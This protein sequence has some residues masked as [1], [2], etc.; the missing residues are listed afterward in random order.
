[1][2]KTTT[3]KFNY[4]FFILLAL[5]WSGS[6]INIKV[7]VD[8]LPPVFC[9]MMRIFISMTALFI[10]FNLTGKKMFA[11]PTRAWPIWLAGIFAQA[12]PFGLL[13]YG[14]KF[15]APAL[16]SIIN[17]TVSFWAL[18]LGTIFFRDFS[19]WTPLKL[20]G[21]LLGF[22]GIVLIFLPFIHQGQSSLIGV[23]SVTGMAI[24]YAI[25]GLIN[26]HMIFNK[27]EVPFETN[28]FQQHLISV[29]VLFIY[30]MI[31]EPWPSLSSILDI[32]V[33]SSFLYLGLMATAIAWVIYFYLLR[34]WGAVRASS[35]MYI[36]PL[37]AICWDLIFLQLEPTRNELI[38][39]L[40]ILMGV[41][42][43]QWVRKPTSSQPVLQPL[44]R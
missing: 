35:V 23:I 5:L 6:F 3:S 16:A 44:D 1:M 9:A 15:I 29:I 32:K 30:S 36:V 14:E 42:L 22:F 20:I 33:L 21:L 2:N 7:V 27:I 37:L 34:E 8:H 17:S 11:L 13:F 43:I 4:L 18:L 41:I 12:L 31:F 38:G 28:L 19:Q 39:M 40:A 26:Q 25:G 10:L 24:A